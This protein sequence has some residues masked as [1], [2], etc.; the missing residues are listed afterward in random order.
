MSGPIALA[1][2]S[3]SEGNVSC[4]SVECL[5]RLHDLDVHIEMAGEANLTPEQSDAA[6]IQS[7]HVNSRCS[8]QTHLAFV[9]VPFPD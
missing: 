4:G 3:E 7:T 1:R 2:K 5:E 6:S 8:T 9:P